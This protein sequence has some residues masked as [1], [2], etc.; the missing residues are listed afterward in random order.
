MTWQFHTC[1]KLLK[2]TKRLLPETKTVIGG[3][4][5]TLMYET[6]AGSPDANWIDFMIRGEGEMA[7]RSLVEALSGHHRFE[8]IASLSY[9]TETGFHHNPR[10]ALLDLS[11]IALPVRDNR[12][13]TSGYHAMNRKIEVNIFLVRVRT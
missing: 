9:K 7:F 11:R 1:V 10:G 12:R 4:H 8:D 3:Y 2:L 13:L 5:A 6:I